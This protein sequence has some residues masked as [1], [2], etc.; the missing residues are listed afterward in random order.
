MDTPELAR[1]ETDSVGSD[2][3]IAE[4]VYVKYMGGLKPRS[5]M[6]KGGPIPCASPTPILKYQKIDHVD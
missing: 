6:P 3:D 2:D 4:S 5:P 1:A